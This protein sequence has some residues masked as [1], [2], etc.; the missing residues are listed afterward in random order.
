VTGKGTFVPPGIKKAQNTLKNSFGEL[1]KK[2]E[3]LTASN[4]LQLLCNKSILNSIDRFRSTK[5]SFLALRA[6]RNLSYYV[7]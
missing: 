4:T 7:P 3:K 5:V 1:F 6:K 2:I